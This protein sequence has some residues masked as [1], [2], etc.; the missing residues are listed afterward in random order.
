MTAAQGAGSVPSRR[1]AWPTSRSG[2]CLLGNDLERGALPTLLHLC[3]A[4]GYALSPA[5]EAAFRLLSSK[6]SIELQ[7]IIDAVCRRRH[8]GR[9]AD[10]RVRGPPHRVAGIQAAS[11]RTLPPRNGIHRRARPLGRPPATRWG[12]S[13][14]R[15]RP[16]A[17]ASVRRSV[18]CCISSPQIALSRG[19]RAGQ[20]RP[21]RTTRRSARNQLCAAAHNPFVAAPAATPGLLLDLAV[22]PEQKPG[23]RSSRRATWPPLRGWAVHPAL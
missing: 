21:Q 8:V 7:H 3:A 17:N 16:H 6:S 19:E 18:M 1:L 15:T 11:G 22:G 5:R 20:D 2:G 10:P 4:T 9:R 14:P 13:T 23:P 12:P